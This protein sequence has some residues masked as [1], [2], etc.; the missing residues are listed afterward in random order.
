MSAIE[1][2]KGEHA[3]CSSPVGGTKQDVF[4]Q[5]VRF[6][7]SSD[8]EHSREV[9]GRLAQAAKHHTDFATAV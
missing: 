2:S 5:I 1:R 4:E 7:L 6:T 8:Y 3:C 9:V